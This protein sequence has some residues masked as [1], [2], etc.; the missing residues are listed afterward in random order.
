[1]LIHQ[2]D[3]LSIYIFLYLQN[4]EGLGGISDVERE[5]E[6]VCIRICT[7]RPMCCVYY[8]VYSY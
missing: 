1:M 6:N 3:K 5:M 4:Q 7:K 2:H 8:C